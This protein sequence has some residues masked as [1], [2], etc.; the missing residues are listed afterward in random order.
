[1]GKEKEVHQIYDKIFKKILTLSEK[2]VINMINGLF[3]TDYPEDSTIEYH[4]TEFIDDNLTK[5]LADTIITVNGCSNYHIEAQM[6]EDENIMMRVIDYGYKQGIRDMRDTNI[7]RFPKARILYFG[8]TRNI[9]DTYNIIFDFEDQGKFEYKIKTFKYQEHSVEEINNRKMIILIPFELLRLRELL[10][11]K[12]T[13]ENLNALKEL[14]CND[15]I[16]SIQKNYSLGNITGSDAGRLMQLTKKL[17]R[18]LY[19]EYQQMEVVEEMDESLILEYEDLD[20]KYAAIDRR[21]AELNRRQKEIDR[22]L[23]IYEKE[24]VNYEKT[25]EDYEKTKVDY[26]NLLKESDEKDEL[27]KK[28]MKENELLKGSK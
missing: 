23:A 24:M 15:I 7:L 1:M 10:K 13:R 25:K 22:K 6:Y 27:I 18:Y 5:T 8:S 11:K 12:R 14:V 9:P 28:L 2:A 26:E 4:W 3:D 20:R 17:Y 19:S 21:Q 16:G